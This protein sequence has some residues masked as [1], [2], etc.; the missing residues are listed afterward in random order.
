MGIMHD[1]DEAARALGL[2]LGSD[3]FF[4][5]YLGWARVRFRVRWG[6]KNRLGLGLGLE[7]VFELGLG[8]E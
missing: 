5:H 6:G 1:Q 7:E 3:S 8:L 2:G 4:R